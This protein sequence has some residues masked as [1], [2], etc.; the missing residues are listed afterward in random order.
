VGTSGG[1]THHGRSPAKTENGFIKPWWA[2]H[3]IESPR[4]RA[5]GTG[6][7]GGQ[8]P[9]KQATWG[10]AWV[11]KPQG[12]NKKYRLGLGVGALPGMFQGDAALGS[13]L[14]PWAAKPLGGSPG[15]SETR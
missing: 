2:R 5:P 11:I 9:T 7:T 4:G 13:G 14:A 15:P 12:S 1:P 8:S 10:R 3:R 6:S